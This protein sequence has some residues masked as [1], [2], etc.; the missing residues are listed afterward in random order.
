MPELD[1]DD[2]RRGF[3]KHACTLAAVSLLA[4]SQLGCQ[5]WAKRQHLAKRPFSSGRSGTNQPISI[6]AVN[7]N[8]YP[9]LTLQGI[10]AFSKPLD[11]EQ[12]GGTLAQS[13]IN[14]M[15]GDEV[16]EKLPAPANSTA[17]TPITIPSAPEPQRTPSNSTSKP[18]ATSSATASATSPTIP[19]GNQVQ[20]KSSLSGT[21]LNRVEPNGKPASIPGLSLSQAQA[22]TQQQPSSSAVAVP[23]PAE[24]KPDL[25]WNTTTN[26]PTNN[27]PTSSS[28][29]GATT[30]VKPSPGAATTTAKA[31]S[32]QDK[33]VPRSIGEPPRIEAVKKQVTP[34]AEKAQPVAKESATVKDVAASK[35]VAPNST[36]SPIPTP[37]PIAKPAPVT[38]QPAA[39]KAT[40]VP[41]SSKVEQKTTPASK[42]SSP[43]ED[44]PEP[45]SLRRSTD[46]GMTLENTAGQEPPGNAIPAPPAIEPAPAPKN[47]TTTKVEKPFAIPRLE[48]CSQVMGFG[49]FKRMPADK[50][51]R[52]NDILLYAEL[53][54]VTAKLMNGQHESRLQAW[55]E[56]V[57]P[58]QPPVKVDFDNIVDR[59]ETV[60]RDFFCH[61]LFTLP[62]ELTQG[63]WEIRL[64][65]VDLATQQKAVQTIRLNVQ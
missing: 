47:V 5:A 13:P 7:P 35:S 42:P 65:I 37:V 4:F 24:K 53:D 58:A 33:P 3:T 59:C 64:H 60:R 43:P 40:P 8:D 39:P 21:A 12:G 17:S 15:G 45:F 36:A 23:A 26:A 55:V 48:A 9:G 52:G 14:D 54:G 51:K 25:V 27:K 56:I 38:T 10:N 19:T 2:Q 63:P 50:I 18:A 31:A 11:E 44:L 49:S 62:A 57:P 61:F 32:P 46:T 22:A 1:Q 28:P 34:T 30:T 20:P 16:L 29:A 41:A 6:G